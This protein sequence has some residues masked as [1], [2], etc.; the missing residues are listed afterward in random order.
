MSNVGKYVLSRNKSTG[1]RT[2]M[3]GRRQSFIDLTE[4]HDFTP[5]PG[6]YRAPSDFGHYD[7]SKE[8]KQRLTKSMMLTKKDKITRSGKVTYS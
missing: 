1:K 7:C 8:R 4:K 6:S 2:F 3:D 5:G